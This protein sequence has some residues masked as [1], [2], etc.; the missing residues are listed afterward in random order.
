MK[1]VIVVTG[2]SGGIGKE[3]A[4]ELAKE[5]FVIGTY[6]QSEPL[7][8]IENLEMKKVDLRNYE[9]I[10]KFVEQ[11]EQQYRRVDV[12]INNAA[13]S[14]TKLFTEITNEDWQNMIATNLSAVFYLTRDIAKLMISQRNGCII[15]VSSIWGQTGGS[16]EVHYSMAK[17]GVDGMTKAL[18]KELGPS[19]IRVNSIAP[20]MI[21]TRMN[22]Y[23]SESEKGEIKEQ[24]PLERI[25]L[26]TRYYQM[27][28]MAY[29]R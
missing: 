4:L 18:A 2:A 6:F 19:H 29:G 28:K 21:E 14:Q 10:A 27:C 13:I 15:N 25:R 1:K 22:D 9:E 12:L 5:N 3:L 20:G 8:G 23:L 7:Q 17:A 26:S 24:I 16:C 11:I